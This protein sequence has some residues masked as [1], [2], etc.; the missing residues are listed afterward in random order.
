M[1]PKQIVSIDVCRLFQASSPRFDLDQMCDCLH[2]VGPYYLGW[3]LGATRQLL[4]W[5]CI[6]GKNLNVLNTLNL[7]RRS[8]E[9]NGALKIHMFHSLFFTQYPTFTFFMFLI[10]HGPVRFWWMVVHLCDCIVLFHNTLHV[11]ACV[12]GSI[13]KQVS[14]VCCQIAP[15]DVYFY[16]DPVDH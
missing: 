13:I 4:W 15:V 11:Y 7:L 16:I 3:V 14:I 8:Q 2:E 1:I 6:T 9:Y 12:T 5:H 10:I